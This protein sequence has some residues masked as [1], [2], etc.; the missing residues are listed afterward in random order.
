MVIICILNVILLNYFF[1]FS[2][3]HRRLNSRT[4]VAPPFYVTVHLLYREAEF[5]M[6]QVKLVS[7]NKLT[8]KQKKRTREMEGRIFG[9]WGVYSQGG[10]SAERLLKKLSSVYSQ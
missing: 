10:M 4:Q 7:A 2:G 5:V 3:W 1:V 9:V 6:T 8:K